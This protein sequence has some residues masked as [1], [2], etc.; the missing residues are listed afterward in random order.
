MIN[1]LKQNKAEV[2]FI[3]S[4]LLFVLTSKFTAVDSVGI[5]WFLVST[6]T[7]IYSSYC[8]IF[9]P[10]N[11]SYEKYISLTLL[12]LIF[13]S[14]FSL[15]FSNN[16]NE[17][18]F[19][20]SK[21]F[22]IVSVFYVS[23][24]A[25]KKLNFSA[26]NILSLF[27]LS[28]LIETIY[29]NSFFLL[30]GIEELKGISMNKNISSFSMV[31]KLP[32]LVYFI[33]KIDTQINLKLIL[34]R[35]VEISTFLSVII[36]QSRGAIAAL[37]TLYII[38]MFASKKKFLL[39]S[40]LFSLSAFTG[41]FVLYSYNTYNYLSSKFQNILNLSND[42]SLNQRIDYYSN[43]LNLFKEK[44][45]LGNG[46]GSFKTE[47]LK[48]Y[49]NINTVPYYA[50]NDFLQFLSETGIFGFFS[51]SLF[52]ILITLLIL[53]NFKS[54]SINLFLLVSILIYFLNSLINFPVHRPQEIIPFILL[55]AFIL[56]LKKD[57]KYLKKT[58]LVINFLV[59]VALFFTSILSFKQHQSLVNE[60]ILKKQYYGAGD[61]YNGNDFIAV[62]YKFPNLSSN[63]VPLATYMAKKLI[64]KNEYE[65]ANK[66]LDYSLK[67]N[68]YMEITWKDKLTLFLKSNNLE[69]AFTVSKY[70][71]E[72]N[73][74]NEIYGEIFFSLSSGL[75]KSETFTSQSNY[76]ESTNIEVHY[77]FFNEYSKLSSFNK[78]KFLSKLLLSIN[79]FPED[80]FLRKKIKN[81]N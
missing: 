29:T 20:L 62:N 6:S 44:P 10:Y 57:I 15:F 25:L 76:L 32:F 64:V 73:I 12:I 69:E 30:Y 47:S 11:F 60:N 43:A 3:T 9:R 38:L 68:P 16:I 5:R 74:N 19:S 48:F 71:F 45:L 40:Y 77:L 1:Q 21:I 18:I 34:F 50:H 24:N 37:L 75:N 36:L 61:K 53:K 80:Q 81:I 28:L 31:F 67:V 7:L 27:V 41:M 8:L 63:T 35:V 54:N 39:K 52:F 46:I 59:V 2:L 33:S 14:A 42:V 23:F 13:S 26:D 70:L 79:M 66:L 49:D 58:K 55:S 72:K 65:K 22:I 78:S 17:S 51:Y 56:L 4:L